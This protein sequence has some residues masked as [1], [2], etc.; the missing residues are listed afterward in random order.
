[1][2]A[3][4]SV[5]IDFRRLSNG[6]RH[7]RLDQPL[8]VDMAIHHFDLMRYVLDQDASRMYCWTWNPAW[9]KFQS[10]PAGAA[11]ITFEAGTVV[12]Y[13][14]SWIS[15]GPI[16]PW[17]GEW[18]MELEGG[19]VVWTSRSLLDDDSSDRVEIRSRGGEATPV[20]LVRGRPVD[21]AGSLDEF[22][23]A[24]AAGGSRRARA[25]RTCAAWP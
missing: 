20:E 7:F 13:R 1:M 18:R 11:I 3:V 21:L 14:G 8:L 9:S 23:D 5:G 10:P 25:G 16:T 4:S 6:E 15:R 12:S 17:A 2:G 19:E 22:V 24:I